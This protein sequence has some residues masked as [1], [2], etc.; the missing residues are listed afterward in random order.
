[1]PASKKSTW[2]DPDEAP[3]M[4]EY[5]PDLSRG[6]WLVDGTPATPE[7]GKAHARKLHGKRRI[8]LLLD[9]DVLAFFQEKSVGSDYQA[10][11]N[12]AL[13]EAMERETLEETLRRVIRE[14]IRA[15]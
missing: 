8:N 3:D 4:S 15:G 2:I 1:M 9:T 14:E 5:D 12:A 10:L 13:R 7:A 6:E 11:I